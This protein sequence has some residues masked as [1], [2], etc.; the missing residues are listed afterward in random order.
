VGIFALAG[1]T[2]C[3]SFYLQNIVLFLPPKLNSQKKTQLINQPIREG[4]S[5]KGGILAAT[6]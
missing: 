3:H 6:A 1:F 4:E 2:V 5:G